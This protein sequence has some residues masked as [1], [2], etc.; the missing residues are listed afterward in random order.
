MET[1]EL[2]ITIPENHE[3]DWQESAKQEKIVFKKK[4]T[5]Q[6]SWEEYCCQQQTNNK[7]GYYINNFTSEIKKLGWGLCAY[8]YSSWRNVLP[9]KELA[10]AFLA[11]MQLMSLRQAWIG[12][13][14]PDW[15]NIKQIKSNILCNNGEFIVAYFSDLISRPLS[16]PTKEM[17]TDF[18]DCFR[19]L[20]EIAK[21]LL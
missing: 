2:K 11:M 9:S 20:L 16:F 5:K 1:K 6:R 19:D 8:Q 21:P 7:D 17:A 14:E 18:M 10:E 15:N 4:D 12:N 3:I 13:W